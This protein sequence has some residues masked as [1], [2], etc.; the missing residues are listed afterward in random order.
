MTLFHFEPEK[1]SFGVVL[2]TPPAEAVPP[3]AKETP[4]L[5]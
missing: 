2:K 5:A 1:Q 4:T 3:E